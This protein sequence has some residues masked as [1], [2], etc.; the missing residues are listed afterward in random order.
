MV[1][2]LKTCLHHLSLGLL[3][4]LSSVCHAET[5]TWQGYEIHYTTFSSLLIPQEVAAQHQISR[6]KNRIVTN[7]SILKD[8]EPQKAIIRGRNSNLLNQLYDMEFLE[9]TESSAIYY[10]SNQLI[11]ERDTLRFDIDI[12]LDEGVEPYNLKFI[13]QY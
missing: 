13:R 1:C 3:L 6:A 2:S 9:V 10:L 4:V 8:G 11:D 7:I 5:V 12:Q